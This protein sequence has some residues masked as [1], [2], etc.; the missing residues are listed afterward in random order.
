MRID[1]KDVKR[2]AKLAVDQ[3]RSTEVT[4]ASPAATEGAAPVQGNDQVALSAKAQE[5]AVAREALQSVPE[6]RS[7]R[8]AELKRQVEAG[9]YHA[10]ADDIADKMLNQP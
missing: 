6:T 1:P 10:S 3:V 7:D 9:G 2:V 8:V 4:P 5:V